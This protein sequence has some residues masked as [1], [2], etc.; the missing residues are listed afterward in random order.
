L[1]AQEDSGMAEEAAGL[2][3]STGQHMAAGLAVMAS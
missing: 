3:T 1:L 2:D